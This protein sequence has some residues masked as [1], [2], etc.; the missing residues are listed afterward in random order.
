[1]P[2]PLLLL[3]GFITLIIF[4]EKYK[5]WIFSSCCVSHEPLKFL[6][7]GSD[8]FLSTLFC[9]ILCVLSLVWEENSTLKNRTSY[10]S[11]YSDI[12]VFRQQTGR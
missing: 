9:T 12:Y 5:S 3:F 4:D 10:R 6:L 7:V 11:V 8:I 2:F 1:M